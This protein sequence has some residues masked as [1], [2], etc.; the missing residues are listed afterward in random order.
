MNGVDCDGCKSVVR[1]AMIIA[2]NKTEIAHI[3][4][5][6]VNDC[7]A[8][9]LPAAEEA[10]CEKMASGLVNLLPWIKKEVSSLAWPIAEGICSVFIP[11]C[12]MPCCNAS[13]PYQPEQIHLALTN[14]ASEMMVSW[15]TLNVAA[16]AQVQWGINGQFDSSTMATVSTYTAAGWVGTIYNALMTKLKPLTTYSYRVGSDIS[17]WSKVWSFK[18]MSNYAD[19]KCQN[20][21]SGQT[22]ESSSASRPPLRIGV[23]G[24]MSYDNYSDVTV[25]HL[26][27][28]VNNGS[29][30]VIIHAG[31]ISYA[32]GYQPHW[33]L[34]MRKIEPL[35]ARVPYMVV[36]GNHEFW[37]NFTA[38]KARWFM[39]GASSGS[40]DPSM[41]FSWNVGP[42]HFLG[43]DTETWL[44]TADINPIQQKWIAKDLTAAQNNRAAQPWVIAMGHRPLYCSNSNKANCVSWAQVLQSKLEDIFV[45]THVDLVIQAHQHDYERAW[46]TYKGKAVWSNYTNAPAPAYVVNGAAGNREGLTGGFV[47]PAPSWVAQRYREYGF[48]KIVWTPNGNGAGQLNWLYY[49]D[50]TGVLHDHFEMTKSKC[51]A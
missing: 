11:A 50:A 33:D 8:L 32:D 12:K 16:G 45:M 37:F 29:I 47:E 51:K 30:D 1:A 35:A 48:G 31:D 36:P 17:G 39:P 46:P 27:N 23:I 41:F 7:R 43:Y 34:F 14:D 24:D 26:L 10:I 18:T 44:D 28:Q 21:K 5:V 6:L 19:Y 9:H 49:D 38:Y 42:L 20:T 22:D 25:A 2:D 3:I 13:I 15:V 40:I 4:E